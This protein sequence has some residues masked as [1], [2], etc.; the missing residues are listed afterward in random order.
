[1]KKEICGA[2]VIEVAP[3]GAWIDLYFREMHRLFVPI[4]EIIKDSSQDLKNYIRV[5]DWFNFEIMHLHEEGGGTASYRS[6][7]GYL[8]SYI[9]RMRADYGKVVECTFCNHD[10]MVPSF[11]SLIMNHHSTIVELK[12]MKAFTCLNCSAF[13]HDTENLK[14]MITLGITH[15]ERTGE[16]K[17]N[18]QEIIQKTSMSYRELFLILTCCMENYYREETH[19]ELMDKSY[20]WNR[21]NFMGICN[22]SLYFEDKKTDEE[23]VKRS[24]DEMVFGDYLLFDI[25]G[26]DGR[27]TLTSCKSLAEVEMRIMSGAGITNSFTNEQVAVVHG[28]V[29]KYELKLKQGDTYIFFKKYENDNLFFDSPDVIFSWLN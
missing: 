13:V 25:Y 14:K 18:M 3:E 7:N 16:I 12:S 20:Y 26:H 22:E 15:H 8:E 24:G 28:E 11:E 5:D 17:I 21:I 6:C 1:V 27:Y 9:D 10:V 23:T 29:K 2:Q 4:D 19:A